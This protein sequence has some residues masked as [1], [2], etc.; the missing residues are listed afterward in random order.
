LV[1]GT[2]PWL[3]LAGLVEGFITPEGIGLTGVLVVGFGLAAIYWTLV[4]ALGFRARDVR[5]A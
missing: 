3:V 4:V 1:L 5:R 2:A